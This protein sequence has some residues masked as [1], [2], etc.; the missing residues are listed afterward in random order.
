VLPL[1]LLLLLAARPADKAPAPAKAPAAARAAAARPTAKV[2]PTGKAKAAP[3]A[4]TR[5]AP[6]ARAT[7]AG[8]AKAAPTARA[9]ATARAALAALAR[10]HQAFLAGD[11]AKAATTLQGL[12]RQLPRVRDYALY[13][14]AESEFYA[15]R[16]GSA[17]SL[18][19]ELGG[20]SESRFA[21]IAPWRVADCLWAEGRKGEAAAAYRRLLSSRPPAGVDAVVARFR[22]AELAAPDEASATFRQIHAEHPAHPLAEEA[23]RRTQPAATGDQD[24]G[25]DPRTV[26]RRAARLVEGR[27]FE[28]AVSE[29]E[30]LPADLPTG[31]RDERDFDLGMAKFRTRHAYA[32][33][34]VLLA[35]VAPRLRGDKA[36]FAAFHAARAELR[37]GRTQEAIDGARQVVALYPGS[38]WAAE[39]QFLVGWLE[40]NRGCY[41]ESLAGLQT[42]IDRHPRTTFAENAAW[43]L[44][45]AQHFLGRPD[46]A[47]TALGEY[48]KLAGA[49]AEAARRVA[50]WRGRFL[51]AR[52][53]PDEGM[54]VWRGLIKDDPFSYYGLLAAARLREAKQPVRVELP[55]SDFK[56]T[57]IARKTAADP[58]LLRAEELA[59]AGLTVEAGVELFRS[60]AALEQRL[61]RDQAL[62]VLLERYPRYEGF[63]RAFQ[64]AD[65][66]GAAT[67]KSA[68]AGGLRA[69]WEAYYPRAY[70]ALVEREA[71]AARVPPL[72]VYSIMHKESGFG[73]TRSSP[74]DARGLMQLMP[75]LGQTMTAALRI[76]FLAED[77]FRPEVNVRLGTRRLGELSA[78]FQGQ[79]HLMAG[80]YN[81]GTAAV[82]RWLER[83]GERP[84]DEFLELAGFRESREYMKRVTG[85]YARYV[86]LYTGKLPDLSLDLKP[87][88]KEPVRA[89]GGSKKAAAS[90]P[91]RPP[92]EPAGEASGE[93]SEDP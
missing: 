84:L 31:L 50:Y 54:D 34:A 85:I 25:T 89:R 66:R 37:A 21:E 30:A 15:G 65:S 82:Q 23:A 35:A 73:P 8:R 13:L 27:R 62:T 41:E 72:F 64:L 77:L 22:L 9:T 33:A 44:A 12:H 40:F 60:E 39:A 87:A 49:D 79:L 3:A 24:G 52:G 42:T 63:R 10:G 48:A 90:T 58:A 17:R 86:Y 46:A 4:K 81:G 91:R 71:K 47:L 29:L 38:R 92:S 55:R 53:S 93:A 18:Y 76:P 83:Q 43:H 61:G 16:A 19:V 14:Q 5:A 68:P 74:V 75:A 67:L 36:A 11:Y 69:L 70:R 2:T 78:L 6:A 59:Q 88:R 20:E 56:L 7:P 80:A 45:L 32:E 28:E 26:L 57:P 51:V 1:L